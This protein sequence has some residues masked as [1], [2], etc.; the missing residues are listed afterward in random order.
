MKNLEKMEDEDLLVSKTYRITDEKMWLIKKSK[1]AQ[2]LGYE[3]TQ[4]V[5]PLLLD[6]EKAQGD[7]FV[8]LML[9]GRLTGWDR[10]E[11]SL[12]DDA[13]FWIDDDAY[14]LEVEMENHG[15]DR[16]TDKV[17][18]YKKYFRETHE[19]FHVLFVMK[20]STDKILSVFEA[21]NTTTH[22]K[23]CLLD[24]VIANPLTAQLHTNYGAQVF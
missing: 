11:R 22:Y 17:V 9:S 14:Y 7:I 6:H 8:S 23:A 19:A 24:E 10:D 4:P 5:H 2:K 1:I 13:K 21:E 18:R 15:M 16:L 20:Q 3:P 12:K